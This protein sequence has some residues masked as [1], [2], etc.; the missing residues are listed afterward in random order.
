MQW[1]RWIPLFQAFVVDA[2]GNELQLFSCPD[3]ALPLLWV[4]VHR[5]M[6]RHNTPCIIL[7][8]QQ[9]RTNSQWKLLALTA[10]GWGC[11]CLCMS[12]CT[13]PC[14]YACFSLIGILIGA[15]ISS[16]S[17]ITLSAGGAKTNDFHTVSSQAYLPQQDMQF[18]QFITK[19][20]WML[21]ESVNSHS[22]FIRA[23]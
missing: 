20:Q 3:L 21:S 15:V 4:C 16:C 11:V 13:C 5:L 6:S 12:L 18:S 14:V 19:P 7:H 10:P 8:E 23:N 22:M 9:H 17:V 1:F 2:L